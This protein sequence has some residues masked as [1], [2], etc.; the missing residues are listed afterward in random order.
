MTTKWVLVVAALACIGVAGVRAECPSSSAISP[1]TCR[2]EMPGRTMECSSV[3]NSGQLLNAFSTDMPDSEFQFFQ[4]V[5]LEGRCT[6]EKIPANVFGTTTFMFVWFGQTDIE[7]VDAAAFTGN[8]GAILELTIA[9]ANKLTAYPFESVGSLTSIYKL[10]ITYTLIDT[11][12]HV[13]PAPNLTQVTVSNGQV[14]TIESGAVAD[15][16]R[17]SRLDLHDNPLTALPDGS[18]SASTSEPWVVYLDGCQISDISPGAFSGS[19]P[20]GVFL[21]G[22]QMTDIPEATFRPLLEN[23][24]T[25]DAAGALT[26]Y[27]DLSNNP[28]ECGCGVQWITQDPALQPYLKNA[29]CT[30]GDV[31]GVNVA[32]LPDDFFASC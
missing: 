9:D 16:P 15:L 26:H 32:D 28:L 7:S 22:N 3:T 10:E 8:E 1:C 6:L 21:N 2:E 31:N 25:Q 30:N 17:L 24:Q 14:S 13:G 23:L 5:K 19:L 27:I 29:V 12:T 18:L 11:L 4:I 20:A